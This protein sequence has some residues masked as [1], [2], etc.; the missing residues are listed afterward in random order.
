MGL[1]NIKNIRIDLDGEETIKKELDIKSKLKKIRIKILELIPY[2]FIFLDEDDN[3]IPKN[4]ESKKRLLDI[5]DGKNLHIK[6]EKKKRKKLGTLIES[7]DELEY[8]LY[9]QI[10]I[11]D[12]QKINSTNI[13]VIGETGVG[14]STW[15]HSL[16]NYM[17]DI[18]IEEDIRYLLFNEKEMKEEYEKKY[19]KKSAGSSVTDIP[20]IYNIE[21][22]KINNNIIRLIDIAGFG[23]TRGKDYDEKIIRDILELYQNS[24]I[25]YLNAVCLIFKATETRAHERFK[26]IMDKVFSI[27][28][29]DIK[30]N[31]I[32]IFTFVDSFNEIPTIKTLKDNNLPFINILGNIEDLNYYSFNNKA[33]FCK[34][35]K[36]LKNVYINNTNNFENFLKNVFNL[37]S[38]SLESSRKVI[39]SRCEIKNKISNLVN[40]IGYIM[41]DVKLVNNNSKIISEKKDETEILENKSYP[42]YNYNYYHIRQR[43]SE[44]EKDDKTKNNLRKDIQRIQ[45][46]LDKIKIKIYN[47]LLDGINQ[48]YQITLINNELNSIAL[49]KD[50]KKNDFVRKILI[51]NIE[52]KGEKNKVYSFLLNSLED[53]E[54]I[55][56]NNYTKENKIKDFMKSLWK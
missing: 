3:E 49:K 53:I 45:Y 46:E 52:T 42:N 19:G 32:I 11:T 40:N 39:L 10:Q 29:E 7:N 47:D 4:E 15:I 30:N 24:E 55:G 36:H 20:T 34:E 27:F 38:I 14:K 22:T 26:N 13:M 9:P 28:G 8:Y 48:L 21:S 54:N 6:K 43:N 18:E 17:Q 2:P 33:Y 1:S 12:E 35:R 56:S 41:N 31:I 25:K 37:E 51:E 50:D 23:D 16:L 5:L 44:K